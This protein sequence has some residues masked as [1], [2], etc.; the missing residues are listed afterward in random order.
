[1]QK[2]GRIKRTGGHTNSVLSVLPIDANGRRCHHRGVSKLPEIAQ[3]LPYVLHRNSND[4][5]R[6]LL[7]MIIG[8]DVKPGA[9]LPSERSLCERFGITRGV[10]REAIRRLEQSHVIESV[11]GSGHRVLDWQDTA[12]IDL[13]PDLLTASD[14]HDPGLVVAVMEMRSALG[15]DA[16]R[17]CATVSPRESGVRLRRVIIDMMNAPDAHA[18]LAAQRAFWSTVIRGS[19]NIAYRLAY[20]SLT[21]FVEGAGPLLLAGLTS[22]IEYA[23]GYKAVAAAIARGDAISA[24]HVAKSLLAR[25]MVGVRGRLASSGASVDR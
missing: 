5:Y 24:E 2:I 4:V 25:G 23:D 6:S 7:R 8:G 1:M 21:R 19:G 15:P 13:L 14:M 16:A 9:R 3:T 11:Q 12:G 22:E 20:N 17:L 18:K 10:I